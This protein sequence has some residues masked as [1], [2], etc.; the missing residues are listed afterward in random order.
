MWENEQAEAQL[1][2]SEYSELWHCKL[3]LIFRLNVMQSISGNE[4][5]LINKQK[6]DF[7]TSTLHPLSQYVMCLRFLWV[8]FCFCFQS[9]SLICWFV[10]GQC[11][12]FLSLKS[13][14]NGNKID[15]YQTNLIA[16]RFAFIQVHSH[17]H[18]NCKVYRIFKSFKLTNTVP[19][20]FMNIEGATTDEKKIIFS[21]DEMD[22]RE[23]K[24]RIWFLGFCCSRQWR[25]EN[26]C[27]YD[28]QENSTFDTIAI[29]HS[30][31][32]N[33]IYEHFW[34]KTVQLMLWLWKQLCN[35]HRNDTIF[36]QINLKAAKSSF[37]SR[38]RQAAHHQP[39]N[40]VQSTFWQ[41]N[42]KQKLNKVNWNV[43]LRR[44]TCKFMCLIKIIACN[45]NGKL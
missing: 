8:F 37:L 33:H 9:C 38:L 34:D 3:T 44:Y 10:S 35:K 19:H 31:K 20:Q 28:R 12:F 45:K 42:F 15:F 4:Y 2:Y 24:K 7:S 17:S 23:R 39:T 43:T 29:V 32:I 40:L 36:K 13:I 27:F 16:R 1:M 25:I 6:M 22:R 26:Y 30:M 41:M 18:V 5:T 14:R 11:L 21:F